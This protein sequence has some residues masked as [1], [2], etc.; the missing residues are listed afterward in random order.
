MKPLHPPGLDEEILTQ[1]AHWCMR[2]H[3]ETCT[4]EERLGFQ[5][6]I[7][8]DPRHAFEYARMLEIWDLS[9]ELPNNRGTSKKLLTDPSTA[10]KGVRTM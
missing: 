9:D 10:R 4:T 7:Q 8:S 6:W 5:N 2:L 3:D 1:A